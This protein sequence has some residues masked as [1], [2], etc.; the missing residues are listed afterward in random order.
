MS[1]FSFDND[2][3]NAPCGARDHRSTAR[4]GF[5]VDDSER[6]VDRGATKNTGMTV[7]LDG[8]RLRDHLF[9]PD[10]AWV[11]AACVLDF[12]PHLCGN[13]WGVR[14]PGA[15][16]YLG[17]LRQ[18]ANG[19]HQVRYTLLPGDAPDEQDIGHGWIHSVI[20]QRLGLRTLLIFGR[21][22]AVIDH[23]DAVGHDLWVGT[24]NI[25]L[26]AF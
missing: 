7:Q 12:L 9:D 18:L 10:D 17:L 13:L 20:G 11:A 22:D 16:H 4:H 25:R 6:L 26:H 19:I 24:Y 14:G 1:G 23:L 21:I 2:L 8:L 3:P 5:K 15:K